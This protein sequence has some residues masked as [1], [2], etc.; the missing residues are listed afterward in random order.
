MWTCGIAIAT[1]Q[2]IADTDSTACARFGV[3]P[4]GRSLTRETGA[5]GAGAAATGGRRRSSGASA[6]SASTLNTPMP[7]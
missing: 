7:T 3:M 2:A 4:N 5:P 6:Q 1:Q